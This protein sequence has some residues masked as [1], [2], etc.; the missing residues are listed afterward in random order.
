MLLTLPIEAYGLFLALFGL[1]AIGAVIWLVI[2]A[3]DIARL[4]DTPETDVVAGRARRPPASRGK[5]RAMLAIAIGST[6]AALAIF[7][8]VALRS[9]DSD[10]TRT[11]VDAQRP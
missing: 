9:V 3:R 4:A 11:D 6:I 5:T 10:N 2:H 8:L 7:A 1:I